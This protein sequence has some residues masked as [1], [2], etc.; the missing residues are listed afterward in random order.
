MASAAIQAHLEPRFAPWPVIGSLTIQASP[1]ASAIRPPGSS[2]T[3]RRTVGVIAPCSRSSGPSRPNSAG[4]SPSASRGAYSRIRP[5]RAAETSFHGMWVTGSS[6]PPGIAS[7]SRVETTPSRVIIGRRKISPTPCGDVVGEGGRQVDAVVEPGGQPA[8]RPVVRGA[9][10]IAREEL[11]HRTPSRRHHHQLV[12]PRPA[13]H[14]RR[15][16]FRGGRH[17]LAAPSGVV[18]HERGQQ[19]PEVDGVERLAHVAGELQRRIA[20]D[21]ERGGVHEARGVAEVGA[22]QLPL[23]FL[24]VAHPGHRV[25]QPPRTDRLGPALAVERGLDAELLQPQSEG[26]PRDPR[27]HDADAR[28]GVSPFAGITSVDMS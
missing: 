16:R 15:V 9:R 11:G 1:T 28:H 6:G 19:Q 2:A 22:A 8:L 13:I 3:G 5:G 12:S 14:L 4:F 7:T 26:E 18:V 20:L 10:R 24:R 27:P 23:P 17:D 25:G 21:R